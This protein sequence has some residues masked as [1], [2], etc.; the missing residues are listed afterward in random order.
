MCCETLWKCLLVT[1]FN[2][3]MLLWFVPSLRTEG[4]AKFR[5]E[6]RENKAM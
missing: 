5:I 1:V 6:V 2:M 3:L 4:N